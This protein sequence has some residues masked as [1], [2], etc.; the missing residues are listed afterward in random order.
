MLWIDNP[1]VAVGLLSLLWVVLAVLH[2]DRDGY[3]GQ[4]G[5][6]GLNGF[7]RI[8]VVL[9]GSGEIGVVGPHIKMAVPRKV[10]EDHFALAGVAGAQRFV[11]R[12]ANGVRRL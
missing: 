2:S 1:L 5:Q 10:E 7:G 4:L 6:R 8:R 11:D 12:G 9:Q 3:F